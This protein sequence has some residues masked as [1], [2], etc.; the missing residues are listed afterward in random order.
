MTDISWKFDAKPFAYPD[1]MAIMVR[2]VSNQQQII[3]GLQH[4]NLYTAGIRG[5]LAERIGSNNLPIYKTYRGG[6]I[7]Y[8]GEGQ[9]V[10]YSILNLNNYGNDIK[11]YITMLESWIISYLHLHNI[12]AFTRDGRVGVWVLANNQEQKIAA[13][14][15]RLRKWVTYHGLSLNVNPNMGYFKKIIP[16]GIA[17][18]GV[19]S[20][21]QL[22]Y[23]LTVE[24]VYNK[25]KEVFPWS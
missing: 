1:A 4:S 3:W 12:D 22:G 16:C 5:N 25:M 14:G 24:D 18:Y 8:H 6:A 17:N 9:L 11:Q 15:V 19:T 23:K 13:I 10:I 21:K 20:L 2:Y 7:T